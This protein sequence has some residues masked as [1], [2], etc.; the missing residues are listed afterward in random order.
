M[1]KLKAIRGGHKS[2][3]T[4]LINRTDEKI[5]E[6][7]ISDQELSA[8]IETLVKKRNLL[9]NFGWWDSWSYRSGRYGTRNNGHR[10]IQTT[11]GHYNSQIQG[12]QIKHKSDYGTSTVGEVFTIPTMLPNIK[13]TH[14]INQN[15]NPCHNQPF[16]PNSFDN[17]RQPVVDTNP[18]HRFYHRLPTL[19][20]PIF[21]GDNLLWQTFWK[22]FESSVHS[23]TVLT[24]IQKFTYLKSQLQN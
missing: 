6:N 24:N 13:S 5:A 23:N 18:S 10:R 15:T 7:D 4:R 21:S 17:T 8:V 3:V 11:F 2:A 16:I 22:S 1:E 19:D 12:P 9:K 20:L 14:D